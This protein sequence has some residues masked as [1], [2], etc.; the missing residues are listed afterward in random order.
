MRS[1]ETT[2]GLFRK[3]DIEKALAERIAAEAEEKKSE[4]TEPLLKS[5]T[6]VLLIL[7]GAALV[8]TFVLGI[9]DVVAISGFIGDTGIGKLPWLWTGELLLNLFISATVMQ[10]IDKV[11]RLKMMRVLIA[12]LFFTYTVLAGLFFFSIST[13]TLYPIMYLI[14]A[15]Q[16][17]LFP[18][19]LWNL[20]NQIYTPSEAKRY[21]PALSSG[22]LLGRLSGYSLFTLTGLLG[23]AELSDGLIQNPAILM[24]FSALLYGIGVFVYARFPY[25]VTSFPVQEE[26]TWFENI[27]TSYETIHEVPFFSNVSSLVAVTWVA[28]T[29]LLYNF[30]ATL[31]TASTEGLQFQ[32]VYSAYNISVL[33]LPLLFQWTIGDELLE[34]I[35]P[36]NGYFFLPIT[37]LVAVGLAFFIPGLWGGVSALFISI[38]VYRGWYMPLY[39]SLYTLVQPEYRGRV[40]SL[41]GSYSYVVGS[42]FAAIFLTGTRILLTLLDVELENAHTLD[43][44]AALLAAIGAIYIASRIRATYEDSLLSW[45]LARRKRTSIPVDQLDLEI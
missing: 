15:Q 23:H 34:R 8:N 36:K 40:R 17:I 11:S 45:R 6:L 19:A 20:A 38:V 27:K 7:I 3:K 13:A 9:V 25:V 30:Y 32:T 42:L 1:E 39:Q 28:L 37:I 18:L 21:F 5:K 16:G 43:L 2:V 44:V 29:L 35:S 14:Y 26:S 22:D 10:L 4:R 31:H 33:L 12:T 41:L 24:A